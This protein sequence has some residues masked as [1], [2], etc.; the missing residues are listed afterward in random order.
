MRT[1]VKSL[2]TMSAVLS[3]TPSVALALP[4]QC[5]DVCF[6]SSCDEACAI[7][8]RIWTTCGQYTGM[9]CVNT[10]VDT[11][12]P[13]ASVTPDEAHQAKESSQV[14]SEAHPAMEQA[15]TAGS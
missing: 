8:A 15:L 12:A 14:C 7:G 10:P 9:A 4:P 3:L 2:L 13:V 1:L 5:D 11:S 6:F